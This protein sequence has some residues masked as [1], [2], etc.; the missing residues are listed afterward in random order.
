MTTK[1]KYLLAALTVFVTSLLVY[2]LGS[3]PTV[4]YGDSAELQSA[5]LLGGVAHSSGYPTYILLGQLFGW[6]AWGDPAHRITLMTSFFAALD[7]AILVLFLR[8]LGV[9]ARAALLGAAIYGLSYTF[10]ATSLRAEVYSVALC[11]FLLALWCSVVAIRRGGT[12]RF[13][14]AAWLLGLS[15]TGHLIYAVPVAVLGFVLARRLYDEKERSLGRLGL[16]LACFLLGLTPYLYLVWVDSHHYVFDYLRLAGLAENPDAPP[17]TFDSPWKR[18]AWLIYS[19]DTYPPREFQLALKPMLRSGLNAVGVMFFFEL[20]PLAAPF[21]VVGFL[22][23]LRRDRTIAWLIAAIAAASLLFTSVVVPEVKM[24]PIFAMP[25][26]LSLALWLSM[27]LEQTLIGVKSATRFSHGLLTGL[28][29]VTPIL[30]PLS[31]HGLRS[32]A[33][34]HPISGLAIRL[35]DESRY[36]KTTFIPWLRDF[37]EP[38][39]FGEAVLA[40]VPPDAV[41]IAR[42]QQIT[43]LRYLRYVEGQRPD[44]SFW[45]VNPPTLLVRLSRW[46]RDHAVERHPVVL[47]G[48]I[49]EL[50]PY[51]PPLD[52]L[53]MGEWP[54]LFVARK[55]LRGVPGT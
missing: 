31:A 5:A 33:A 37:W 19:Q 39:R 15:V 46:Q 13:A 6:L 54:T 2:V 22:R 45:P 52:T 53:R 49:P 21:V 7:L 48:D 17:G 43:T 28:I 24:A 3:A 44:L 41:V 42:F 16:F 55:P 51:L 14:L 23:H 9:S 25:C 11:L 32:H 34:R 29:M 40:A 10:W 8:E 36:E 38:R 50:Q 18:V 30:L 20:G 27:G 47:V 1:D 35:E 12:W 4:L 26:V